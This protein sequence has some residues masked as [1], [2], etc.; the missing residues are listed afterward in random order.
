MWFS[1]PIE[2]PDWSAAIKH[3]SRVDPV[4]KNVV[5]RVGPCGL[6]PRRDYFVVLA[7]SIFTQQISTKVATV[8]FNRFRDQFPRR[9]PTPARVRQFL[10]GDEALI[11]LC[12]LSRQKR[13]YISD[14]CGHFIDGKIPTR[15]FARMTD[16][17][18]IESLTRV[19]GIGRWTAEMFLIFVL[20]RPDV[21]PIDD[22]GLQESYKRL[23]GLPVRPTP[24]Q[25]LPLGDVWRPWRTIA[26]YYLWR[27]TEG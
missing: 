13:G 23:Y 18:V 11:K 6:R 2:P 15:Q 9:K 26:T 7:Q 8:L 10:A 22:L 4:M 24:K 20:N 21:F 25:L 27:G 19:N 12:G 5:A 16:E 17:Q 14:L 3:L 1:D